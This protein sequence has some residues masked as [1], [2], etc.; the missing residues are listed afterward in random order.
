MEDDPLLGERSSGGSSRS[1]SGLLRYS[2]PPSSEENTEYSVYD[3]CG[4]N[5][6]IPPEGQH[7]SLSN[8]VDTQYSIREYQAKNFHRP[9]FITVVTLAQCVLLI[10]VCVAGGIEPISFKP[11]RESKNIAKFGFIASQNNGSKVL[12]KKEVF[13]DTGVNAFIGPNA[14]LLVKVGAK[15]VP[16]MKKLNGIAK[17]VKN[18]E[19]KEALYRCCSFKGECAMMNKKSCPGT[20]TGDA[21]CS[22]GDGNCSRGISLRPC[23]VGLHGQCYILSQQ[24]CLFWGGH[25]HDD[26][27][28]CSD[29]NC[30]NDVCG[31]GGVDKEGGDQWFRLITAIFLHLGVIHLLTNMLF[32]VPVGVLIEREIGTVRTLLI[33]MISG[34]GGNLFCGLFNPLT[35]QVG[36]S[37]ALFGLL[38]LLIIKLFQLRHE[39]RRPCMEALIL[40]A[41]A[42]AS[43]ALGTLPYIGNFVHIGG[44]LFGLLASVALL[45]RTNYRF[46]NLA[47]KKICKWV[48]LL[49][50]FVALVCTIVAF[51]MIKDDEFCSWCNYI[52]CV[53]YTENFCPSMSTDG[54][55]DN[56]ME[57]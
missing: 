42:L 43:F 55:L 32:Q 47:F 51:L 36:A 17:Q 12:H 54:I 24:N 31:M 25:W 3:Y 27:V 6:V 23:C 39:V 4:D 7:A 11:S 46:N 18:I 5:Y 14:S 37:G 45:P 34:I 30:L 26:K 49:L 56:N 44:F 1:R 50:L 10:Y 9:L 41:V 21:K 28:L 53:P 40:L 20:I 52:D 16:C 33:Y 19:K 48:S 57:R 8:T 13:R 15:F 35:P 22:L 38:G 2:T 29:V